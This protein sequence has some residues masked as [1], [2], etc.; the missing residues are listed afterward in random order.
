MSA[1]AARAIDVMEWLYDLTE[2]KKVGHVIRK[3]GAHNTPNGNFETTLTRR[4]LVD[5]GTQ[6]FLLPPGTELVVFRQLKR[7]ITAGK[8]TYG[9]QSGATL[10]TVFLMEQGRAVQQISISMNGRVKVR[11][12]H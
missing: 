5:A 10:A 3:N 2:D 1:K 12:L 11:P 6:S 8:K 4:V 9:P 7:Y